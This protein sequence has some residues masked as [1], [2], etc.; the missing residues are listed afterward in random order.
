MGPVSLQ[1]LPSDEVTP[2]IVNISTVQAVEGSYV[3][4]DQ[5]KRILLRTR[6]NS[7]LKVAFVSGQSNTTYVTIP[8]GANLHEYGIFTGITIYFQTSKNDTIEVLLWA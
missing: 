8:G 7:I 5:T 1:Q 3:I 6:L 4:P 2:T